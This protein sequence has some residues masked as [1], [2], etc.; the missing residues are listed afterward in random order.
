MMQKM[1]PKRPLY[2]QLLFTA[3]AF[4]VLVVL[5]HLFMSSIV[6]N[7]LIQNAESVL[8]F[9]QDQIGTDLLEAKVTLSV[10]SRTMR[11]MI[12]RGDDAGHLRDYINN[13]SDHITSINWEGQKASSFDGLYC[14]FETLPDGP[15]F[16]NSLNWNPPDGYIITERP[17]YRNALAAHGDIVKTLLYQDMIS[18]DSGL[19]YACCIFDDAGRHLGVI[20]LRVQTGVVGKGI[21][22][23]AL[24]RSG[25]G[26]LLSE[27]FVILAHPNSDFVNTNLRDLRI[28]IST[29]ADYLGNGIEVAE[30][31]VTSYRNEAAI[32]FFRRLPNGWYL[33]LVSPTGPYYQSVTHMGFVLSALGL[34]L[35]ATLGCV[36]VRIDAAR[37]K[38]DLESRHKSV[39]LSNMSHEIRT[40]MNAIIGMTAIG[41]S[42]EDADRKDY[43]FKKIE[44]AS[45]HLLGVINDILDM[46]KIEANKFELSPE[47]FDF[48]KMLQRVVNVATFHVDKKRQKLAVRIDRAIPPTLIADDQRLAQVITNLLG[49]AVKFT[50]KE[51]SITLEARLMGEENDVCTIQISV[52]DTGIGISPGQEARL[53]T[54]FEQAE[55]STT[56]KYGGTGLGLAISKS[57]VG[58]MGGGIRVQSEPGKGS[59]FAFTIQ[60]K[61]GAEKNQNILS[62]GVSWGNVRIMA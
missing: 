9:A 25:Y 34:G 52:S 60:A 7:H 20:G 22:E 48:E 51:G 15:A 62:R 32:A 27:D 53:F 23:T 18:G 42:I 43:C 55:S 37:K 13:L 61:R 2:V 4:L 11:G 10:F 8:V 16:I 49:N 47:E 57:I 6:H 46:S 59:T 3:L 40:P 28:P 45:N 19:I 33:S 41:K 17:W 12:L 30:H 50:P 14:Y 21:V 29:F 24:T 44:D 54:A 56:R 36:L 26:M 5:S 39:F 58:M 35:A 1:M 38:S 31:S